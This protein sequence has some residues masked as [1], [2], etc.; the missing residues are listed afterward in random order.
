MAG[1]G[2]VNKR[3][4]GL[5]WVIVAAIVSGCHIVAPDRSAAD[6]SIP[7]P[8]QPAEDQ[9]YFARV[10][11]RVITLAQFEGALRLAGRQR[12]YHGQPP[13]ADEQRAWRRAMGEGVIA[14]ALFAMEA[15]RRGLQPDAAAVQSIL[16]GVEQRMAKDPSWLQYRDLMLSAVREEAIR[17]NLV[18]QLRTIVR[19]RP[20]PDEKAIRDYYDQHPDKFTD[21]AQIKLSVLLLK[22]EVGASSETW[23][24]REEEALSVR[25]Q[26]LAGADFA[27]TARAKSGHASAANGGDVGYIEEK[28]LDPALAAYLSGLAV[29]VLSEPRRTGEGF[30]LYR[31]EGR[32]QPALR[33]YEQ[34]RDVARLLWVRNDADTAW[35]EL[36]AKLRKEVPVQVN[37]DA[38]GDLAPAT[39]A[40]DADA[41]AEVGTGQAV[42]G[43]TEK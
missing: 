10:G 12:Y 29:G 5:C 6:L 3:L 7:D 21:P 33:P 17:S 13:T 8:A 42:A 19:D 23:Q 25:A 15:Q 2:D 43:P 20:A 27:E 37:E 26:I 11:A 39:D 40:P 41:A 1:F 32:R 28:S 24:Q 38:Y 4:R 18:E 9:P 34:A 31:I 16:D 30:G 36:L 22:V 14:Q 35:K